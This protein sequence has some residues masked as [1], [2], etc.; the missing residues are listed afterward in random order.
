MCEYMR[1]YA[2]TCEMIF[3]DSSIFLELSILE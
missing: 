2:H 3:V 1:V